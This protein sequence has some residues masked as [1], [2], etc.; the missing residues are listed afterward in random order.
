[1]QQAI[2]VQVSGFTA[3]CVLRVDTVSRSFVVA[4]IG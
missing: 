4:G 1:M 2:G 3:E